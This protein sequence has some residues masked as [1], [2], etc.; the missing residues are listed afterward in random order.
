MIIPQLTHL[1]RLSVEPCQK[2]AGVWLLRKLGGRARKNEKQVRT[3][4][5]ANVVDI[6]SLLQPHTFNFIFFGGS[7]SFP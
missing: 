5:R 6:L 2:D 1:F 3:R 4:P 7:F